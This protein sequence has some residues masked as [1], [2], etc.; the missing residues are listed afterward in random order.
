MSC[1]DC[2]PTEYC[3]WHWT[4]EIEDAGWTEVANRMERW[5]H[6]GYAGDWRDPQYDEPEAGAR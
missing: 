1:P 3:G 4:P 2:S 5:A 6:N